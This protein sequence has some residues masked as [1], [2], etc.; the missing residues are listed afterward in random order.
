MVFPVELIMAVAVGF[1]M[2]WA[3]GANDVANAMASTVGSKTLTVRNAV[4]IAAVF[5]AI[6]AVLASG[7]VTNMIR[8]G[9]VDV[10]MFVHNPHD[11]VLGMLASLMSAATW[12]IVAT[13]K[14]WPVSTT[15]SIIGAVLGFGLVSVGFEHILWQSVGSILLSWVVT[16]LVAIVV[17]F[18]IFSWISHT[19]LSSEK[20]IKQA[21]WVIPL[22][23]MSLVFIFAGVTI[24]QGI[25]TLGVHLFWYQKSLIVCVI[26]VLAFFS[27]RL[28]TT[29]RFSQM[30]LNSTK[31]EL[32]AV[33]KK[34]GILSIMTAASMAYA[35]GSNDVANA[36]GPVA[37]VVQVITS[38]ALSES[39]TVPYW[40]VLLGACG[41]V[42]GLVM[43]GYK[44]METVGVGITQLTP[45]R[46]FS[47]QFSTSAI[48]VVASGLGYP[49]ST[50]QTMV[51]AILGVGLARGMSA[52]NLGIVKNIL[53]SWVVTL[54]MGAVL[55]A[56]YYRLLVA[57]L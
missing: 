37:A 6:G 25:E 40:V 16:P 27:S 21:N 15:H 47:A 46:G 2:A 7:Q 13:H 8:Y 23:M 36:I 28:I 1:I 14:G 24:F 51:G 54:P 55:A 49:V 39:T 22:C 11:F 9:I 17:A 52:L 29:K 57:L 34:F 42:L 44:I 30:G 41:I 48:I 38:G 19:V 43:Y 3:V 18:L 35:H 26:A 56:F 33:E 5:E 20:P 53:V 12:L 45:S 32:D 31:E 4:I 50:T 10:Q